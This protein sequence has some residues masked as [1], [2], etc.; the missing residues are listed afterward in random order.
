MIFETDEN[1]VE[2]RDQCFHHIQGVLQNSISNAEGQY[3]TFSFKKKKPSKKYKYYTLM[4]SIFIVTSFS[5]NV[6]L[7]RNYWNLLIK[8]D[9]LITHFLEN[10][11]PTLNNLNKETKNKA[12]MLK[13]DGSCYFH[14]SPRF[15]FR[16]LLSI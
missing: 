5:T 15:R 16:T 3:P 7:R 10:V 1:N 11:I 13:I 4:R 9:L 6:V 12:S 2:F 14:S 8:G